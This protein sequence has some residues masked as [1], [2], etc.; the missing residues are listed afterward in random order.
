MWAVE[1]PIGSEAG[2]N[3]VIDLVSMHAHTYTGDPKGVVGDIPAEYL[4]AAQA[5]REKLID[6]V[7][8]AD[9]QLIEKYLGGEEITTAELLAG[10]H[11][12][13]LERRIFPV[14]CA[15]GGRTAWAPISCST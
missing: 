1:I 8:E 3:G 13:I 15:A 10:I 7:A 14:V 11:K 6:I 5:A 12:G 9:D 2:F 4:A